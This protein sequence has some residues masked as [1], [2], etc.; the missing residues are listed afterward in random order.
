[1]LLSLHRLLYRAEF[2][3]HILFLEH[4][5]SGEDTDVKYY[6]WSPL[7]LWNEFIFDLDGLSI[8]YL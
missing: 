2:Q 1:M 4:G 3:F 6:L 5:I 8:R 7:D